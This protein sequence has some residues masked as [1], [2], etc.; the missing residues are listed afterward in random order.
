M[1]EAND[2]HTWKNGYTTGSCSAGA[3]KAACEYLRAKRNA[4]EVD[5][6]L[7]QGGRLQLPL[8]W[9][10]PTAYGARACIVKN[11][12]DDPDVTHGL[13][14]VAYVRLLSPRGAVHIEGGNGVG[15]VTKKGLAVPV[16]ASA[17]N[18]VPREMIVR[19]VR[20][21]FAE[22][23]IEVLIEI[24]RGE[25][26]A[27][28]TLNP[29]LGIIGGLSVLG[30]TGIVR[31]MSEEAFKVSILPELD[32]AKAYGH[33]Q[34]ILT[35]GNYGFRV[36]TQ[37]LGVP[38]EAIVQMSNFV[39]FLLEEAAYRQFESVLLLGHIGKLIKV[40]G[41]IFHTHNRVADARMEILLAHAAL[42][43]LS[44]P[45]LQ[46]LSAW[47]TVEGAAGALVEQ[48]RKS[49]LDALAKLASKRARQ[50][51]Q[52]KLRIGTVF[53]RLDGAFIGWDDEAV[54]IFQAA[55]WSWPA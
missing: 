55:G 42:S 3:A 45:E 41:G 16:G 48:G 27:K 32:Q 35:P 6:P 12:G 28:H 2:R 8:K 7:P 17:I 14:I 26:V 19:A 1:T 31:P 4:Q 29:R 36:A 5:I 25:E 33:D 50:Y 52:E 39:G 9:V 24:P 10:E 15:K 51:V 43:G 22:E 38:A 44:Y 18:P 37:Q 23:E 34:I 21:V 46:A 49:I 47:S 30:T 20:E 40:A 54:N 11:G 53:T 13:D